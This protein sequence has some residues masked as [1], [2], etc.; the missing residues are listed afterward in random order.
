MSAL[1]SKADMC[2]ATSDVGYGPKSR[3]CAPSFEHPDCHRLFEI[4]R[5][6]ALAVLKFVDD[7]HD[8]GNK[9]AEFST[10]RNSEFSVPSRRIH[11]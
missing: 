9:D 11:R 4:A 8:N 10:G 2:G 3:H 5:P 1:A 6:C 7:M